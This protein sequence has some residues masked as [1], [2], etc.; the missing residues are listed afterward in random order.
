VAGEEADV[1]ADA[2]LFEALEEWAQG[3]RRGAVGAF[4][5]GGDALADE[6]FGGRGG[7]KAN[8]AVAVGINEAGCKGET[9]GVDDLAGG[10]AGEDADGGDAV[11]R[12]G[13][14]GPAPGA[15]GAVEDA[16]AANENV[17]G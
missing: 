11:A 2:G 10:G 4:D 16:R 12:D 6:V 3:E 17:V 13:D 15:A 5:D 7:L 1:D 14:I 8:A 9:A